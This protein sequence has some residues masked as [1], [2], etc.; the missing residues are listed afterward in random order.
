MLQDLNNSPLPTYHFHDKVHSLVKPQS[1]TDLQLALTAR[2]EIQE[3]LNQT[4]SDLSEEYDS[5]LRTQEQLIADYMTT[6]GVFDNS[7]LISNIGYL[8]KKN[9]MRLGD[10][11]RLLGISPGYIS[12]TAKENSGKRMSIDIVWKI[13]RIFGEDLGRIV[14]VRLDEIKGNTAVLLKLVDKMI[15]QT[16]DGKLEWEYCYRGDDDTFDGMLEC[17]LISLEGNHTV[18]HPDRLNP[19][20]KWVIAGDIYKLWGFFRGTSDLVIIPFRRDDEHTMHYDLLSTYFQGDG[21]K[22]LKRLRWNKMFYSFDDPFGRLDD[23]VA[24]LIEAINDCQFDAL[25]E[26]QMRNFIDYYLKED[27]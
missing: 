24:K 17:G 9:N 22:Q 5:I 27:E 23:A 11:E 16:E 1:L 20:M 14:T 4:Q 7:I 18:Y 13:A 21:N 10:L 6:V 19:E 15:R 12:R 25:V 3:L 8:I 26:P 2:S